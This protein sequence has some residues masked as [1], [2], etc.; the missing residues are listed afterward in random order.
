VPDLL[1]APHRSRRLPAPL[2]AVLAARRTRLLADATG[3]VLDLSSPGALALVE[4]AAREVDPVEGCYDVVV[5]V[6]ELI[7]LPDLHRA[8]VGVERLLGPGGEFR[9]VEPVQH[10]GMA[11]TVVAT[12]WCAH[13]TLAG[14][15]LERD[16]PLVVRTVGLTITDLERFTMPT[17]LWPMRPFVDGRA[18]RI[19]E[20][21][22]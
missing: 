4:R 1:E 20:T 3:R 14:L 13:P 21:R 12:A 10:P 8:V 2:A 7:G 22:R 17:L 16:L 15:H 11:A 18:R 5:S 6:A 19:P 9:F